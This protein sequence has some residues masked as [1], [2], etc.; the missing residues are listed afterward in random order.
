MDYTEKSKIQLPVKII[1]GF[2]IAGLVVLV[3][4]AFS[5]VKKSILTDKRINLLLLGISETDNARFAEVIKLI[6]Y[7]PKTG[8]LDII[9]IPRDSM[10]PVDYEI[11]WKRIQKLD[12]VYSRYERAASDSQELFKMFRNKIQEFLEDAPEIDFYLQIDYSAFTDFVNE[13]GGVEIEVAQSLDYDDNAQNLHIH[14]SSG[15]HLMN[16]EEAL[17]YVRYRD[18]IRGDI[19]RQERQHKF[20]ISVFTRLKSPSTI[21]RLPMLVKAVIKN[22]DTNLTFSDFIAFV[23]ELINFDLK[24]FRIQKI[25]GNP[26][27]KW[28]KSYWEVDRIRMREIL[29][30]VRNSQLINLPSVTVDKNI[31]LSRRITAEVWNASNKSNMAR[32]LTEYLRRRNVDVVRYGNYGV[33]KKYSQVISRTGDLKPAR[34]VASIIGCRNIKTELDSSRMVDVNIVIGSDFKRLWKN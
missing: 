22:V 24:N 6:S 8:F 2:V 7:E 23:D 14:I 15:R 21:C 29:D 4:T 31:K 1:T 12:E 10:V 19:G 26:V 28:G 33:Y 3:M 27:M 20:L 32:E 34:E 11:S 13:L 17:K 30:V 18:K 25:P 5:P 9:S 16:G